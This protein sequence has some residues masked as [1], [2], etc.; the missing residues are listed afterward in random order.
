[1]SDKDRTDEEEVMG[2]DWDWDTIQDTWERVATLHDR[3]KLD[4]KDIR[5]VSRGTLF[6][7]MQLFIIECSGDVSLAKVMLSDLLRLCQNYVSTTVSEM[8]QHSLGKKEIAGQKMSS[9]EIE[10]LEYYVQNLIESM[11]FEQ[12]KCLDKQEISSALAVQDS[13]ADTIQDKTEEFGSVAVVRS[14]A[15]MLQQYALFE[16]QGDI[17]A[18]KSNLEDMMFGLW[19][20]SIHNAQKLVEKATEELASGP[21]ETRPN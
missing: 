14:M 17:A 10:T 9:E 21:A 18:A 19:E 7:A 5:W 20:I 8:M 2:H 12:R 15:V 11:S 6:A 16:S 3:L 4:N 1:M 13:L